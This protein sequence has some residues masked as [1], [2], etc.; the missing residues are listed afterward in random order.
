M[1]GSCYKI[2]TPV[3]RGKLGWEDSFKQLLPTAV[4]NT[5]KNLAGL[6]H[7]VM[8]RTVVILRWKKWKKRKRNETKESLL[9]S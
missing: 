8:Q 2:D 9:N 6:L 7:G 1:S 4:Q 5:V 3:I